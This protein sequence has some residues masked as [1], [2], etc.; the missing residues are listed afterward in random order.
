M[1]W[2][3]SDSRSFLLCG[4]APHSYTDGNGRTAEFYIMNATVATGGRSW[5]IITVERAYCLIW[6][7]LASKGDITSFAKIIF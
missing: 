2:C 3:E 7:K 4:A 5:R 1:D 6:V